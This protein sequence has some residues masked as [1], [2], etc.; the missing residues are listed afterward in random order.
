M[1]HT[2]VFLPAHYPVVIHGAVRE[3]LITS[4]G[5]ALITGV[6]TSPVEA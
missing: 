3:R 1:Q 4:F 2:V 6:D 5:W